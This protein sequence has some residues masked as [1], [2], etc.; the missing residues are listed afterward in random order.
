MLIKDLLE[1][2]K[3]TPAMDDLIR[4]DDVLKLASIMDSENS[5]YTQAVNLIAEDVLKR[6][7]AEDITRQLIDRKQLDAN[8]VF[9]KMAELMIKSIKDL[10]ILKVAI[11]LEKTASSFSLG[12]ISDKIVDGAHTSYDGALLDILTKIGV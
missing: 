9:P 3:D 6:E 5:K 4:S 10:E 2:L 8:E 11:S 7:L 1:S 12:T